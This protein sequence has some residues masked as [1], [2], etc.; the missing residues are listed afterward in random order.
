[1]PNR[2]SEMSKRKHDQI[3]TTSP[4]LDGLYNHENLLHMSRTE[5]ARLLKNL[6]ERTKRVIE[7]ATK[8]DFEETRTKVQQMQR[9]N[10]LELHTISTNKNIELQEINAERNNLAQQIA[11]LEAEL[12]SIS[13]LGIRIA[14]A[15]RE[16]RAMLEKQRELEA[17]VK[18]RR[19]DD[20]QLDKRQAQV[21]AMEAEHKA[22]RDQISAIKN[23]IKT[24]KVRAITANEKKASIE[25]DFA[26]DLESYNHEMEHLQAEVREWDQ[27]KEVMEK[28]LRETFD[29]EVREE[30]Q[31][32]SDQYDEERRSGVENLKSDYLAIE[33]ETKIKLHL[34]TADIERLRDLTS[35]LREQSRNEEKSAI[36]CAE[37]VSSEKQRLAN[38]IKQKAQQQKNAQA[39]LATL[40][41]ETKKLQAERSERERRRED[42]C[43]TKTKID[44]AIKHYRH[45][46]DNEEDRLGYVSPRKY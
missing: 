1:M 30:L 37:R 15:N 46:L 27:P 41:A 3:S 19:L 26:V 4:I 6:L 5:E 25:N 2:P 18:K 7:V 22:L 17:Q 9:D 29:K 14:A 38:L 16:H 33:E 28:S 20:S 31:K 11:A 40:V 35:V 24:L 42:L 21:L 8:R 44:M 45:L 36:R 43:D 13:L 32:K 12:A 23:R 34:S 10:E 39:D